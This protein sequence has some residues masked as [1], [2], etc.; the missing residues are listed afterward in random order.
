M[1]EDE[2]EMIQPRVS[3]NT[4]TIYFTDSYDK[5]NDILQQ[6]EEHNKIKYAC[7]HQSKGFGKGGSGMSNLLNSLFHFFF[8]IFIMSNNNDL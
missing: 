6:H 7:W 3:P 2:D 5:A 1:N 4:F 8:G